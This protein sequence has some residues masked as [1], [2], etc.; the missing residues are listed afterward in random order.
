MRL[1]VSPILFFV[2]ES[3]K[4]AKEIVTLEKNENYARFK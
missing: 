3:A 1:D 2:V 4:L